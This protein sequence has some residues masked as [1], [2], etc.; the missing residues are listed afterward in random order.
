MH[1]P[2]H[3]PLTTLLV[4]AIGLSLLAE[5]PSV[6]AAGNPFEEIFGPKKPDTP[7]P[8]KKKKTTPNSA[9]KSSDDEDEKAPAK[10]AGTAKKKSPTTT[11]KKSSTASSSK[12]KSGDTSGADSAKNSARTT[13]RKG[14]TNVK[15]EEVLAAPTPAP[16]PRS[17][18]EGP[19]ASASATTGAPTPEAPGDGMT[20]S[21]ASD[22]L[23]EFAAQPERVKQLIESCLALTRRNLTY[24]Y[25]SA[26]PAKG[27]M[28]C[29]G[30]IY[31]TLR[32]AGFA[33]TPRQ[34]NEQYVWV[35]KNS[36]FQAVLSR[37]S[38][39]FE[40]NDLRPGDLMFWTGTYAIDRD[41]PVTHTMIY[42]GTSKK[43]GQRVMVGSSDGRTY[44]GQ[45][46]NGV[47]VFDFHVAMS[48]AR[49]GTGTTG[50]SPD[51]AGYGAIPGMR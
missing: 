18:S 42:L 46:R 7:P 31:F 6:R 39:T 12:K 19:A 13:S 23:K 44:L 14:P 47:S 49:N 51:F 33:D 38:D 45:K 8:K 25:G 16:T 27:G 40:I 20:S 21:I 22:E 35:R 3:R 26:D 48:S 11:E 29:S 5:G 10:K 41:P 24:T 2:L 34:A 32:A 36:S 4:I 37:K 43:T 1:L 50:G 15:A 28:D 30:F 9:K 17:K